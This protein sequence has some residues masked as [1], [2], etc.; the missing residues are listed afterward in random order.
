MAAFLLGVG[1]VSANTQA[2]ETESVLPGDWLV[3]VRG[4][5]VNPND[6]S[7]TVRVPALGGSVA[8]SSVGVNSDTVPE[9]D[10][11]YMMTPNWGLE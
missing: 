1:A 7:S 10:I 2:L 6:S 4:I 5:N 9:L 11:T 8:G 3:R